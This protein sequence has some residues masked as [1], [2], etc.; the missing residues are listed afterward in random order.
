M[1]YMTTKILLLVVVLVLTLSC[2]EQQKNEGKIITTTITPLK[3][4][5]ESI[6]EDDYSVNIIV[7]QGA[8]PETYEMTAR[9]V[10]NIENSEFVFSL[11]LLDFEKGLSKRIKNNNLTTYVD[12][13]SGIELM[14][15][16]CTLHDHADDEDAAHGVDPHIWTSISNLKT[17]SKSVYDAIIA[18]Y[19]DSLKYTNNYNILIDSLDQADS[20]IRNK[21]AK[22]DVKHFLIY[23]PALGYYAKEYG[24]TQI[25]LEN[26]GKEPNV[27]EMTQVIDM[28]NELNL[29][30]ILYQKEFRKDV[31]VSATKDMNGECC[32]INILG[33][34]IINDIVKITDIIVNE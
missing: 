33:G 30:K 2:N 32:E 3:F 21:L 19:P 24:L 13:S 1:R 28:A 7:P 27:K 25:A 14:S 20:L 34:N 22:S 5:V 4:I 8:S 9:Q 17:I 16:K 10:I 15:G 31:V 26:E 23:H 6:T 29:N 11:N 12:L 18:K